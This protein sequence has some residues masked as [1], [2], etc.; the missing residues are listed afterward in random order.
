M[1]A[2][3]I[4]YS[5]IIAS[6]IVVLGFPTMVG[7][8]FEAKTK[9]AEI[10]PEPIVLDKHRYWRAGKTANHTWVDCSLGWESGI[11]IGKNELA[12][13]IISEVRESFSELFVSG[14]VRY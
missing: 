10:A 9:G 14:M 6:I 4:T 13:F 1:V 3:I 11:L 8:F 2:N 5:A 12:S 7:V